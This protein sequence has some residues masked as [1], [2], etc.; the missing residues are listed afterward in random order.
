MSTTKL[1]ETS[2]LKVQV[3]DEYE[4]CVELRVEYDDWD[5]PA[6]FSSFIS[7]EKLKKLR[8]ELTRFLGS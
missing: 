3:C 4:G 8:D 5:N 6:K 2:D 1:L 7:R